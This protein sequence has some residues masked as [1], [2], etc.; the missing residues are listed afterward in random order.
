M[1]L[2]KEKLQALFFLSTFLVIFCAGFSGGKLKCHII[3][4]FGLFSVKVCKKGHSTFKW[5]FFHMAFLI[6]KQ[7]QLQQQLK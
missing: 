1:E 3:I 7:L 5:H 2:S 4:F 6:H